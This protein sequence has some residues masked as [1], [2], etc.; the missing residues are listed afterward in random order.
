MTEVRFATDGSVLK[1][2][3]GAG[4]WAVVFDDGRTLVGSDP[5]TT[6]NRMEMMAVLEGLRHIEEPSEVIVECDSQ[7]VC[8]GIM[9]W[10]A[11]WKAGGWRR[12]IK[13]KRLWEDIDAE[14]QRHVSVTMV[15]I[16]GHNGHVANELADKLAGEAARAE[17]GTLFT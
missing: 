4:G 7:Y 12:R 15:W 17:R 13:N 1:N 10:L 11:G 5:V 3:G 8:R 14:L 9:E 2:P 16:K 6:N